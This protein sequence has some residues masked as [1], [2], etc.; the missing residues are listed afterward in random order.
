M[1]NKAVNRCG[2]WRVFR[3]P[4]RRTPPR[5]LVRS[6]GFFVEGQLLEDC[7]VRQMLQS[8]VLVVLA[9]FAMSAS[10]QQPAKPP[11]LKKVSVAEGVELHYVERGKGVPVVFVHG[12]GSEYGAWNAHLGPFAESYRAIAYSRRYNSPN[13][14]K[15]Q[16]KHSPLVEAEDLAALI[17]KLDLG[18]VHIVGHSYGAYIALIL[19]VK[20]PEQIR[21]LTLGEPPAAFSGDG[22]DK[23]REKM[24]RDAQ[25]AFAK[26]DKEGAMRAFSEFIEPGLYEKFPEAIRKQQLQNTLELEVWAAAGDVYPG[27]DREAVRKIDVPVL[28]LSGE[29]SPRFFKQI[30]EELERLL[31]EKGRQ[32]IIIRNAHHGMLFQSPEECREA[33]LKFIK[34]K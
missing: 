4:S 34:D 11:E 14:N 32:H 26:G 5:Y 10:A 33:I 7:D 15:V 8:L 2:G 12:T 20:H 28:L 16:P 3:I 25:A 17:K 21:S 29:K 22:P 24:L 30:E 1:P 13:T 9:L 18:K 6:P 27:L 31:P 23:G 19:A